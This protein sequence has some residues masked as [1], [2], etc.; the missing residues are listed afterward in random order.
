VDPLLQGPCDNLNLY[1]YVGNDPLDKTDPSG[2]DSCLTGTT[3]P[4]PPK[5]AD[6]TATQKIGNVVHNETS[7]LRPA[8]KDGAGRSKDLHDAKVAI[9][10]VV[11]NREKAGV[12]GGVASD[13]ASASEQR[14]SQYKDAQSAASEASQQKDTTGGAKNYVLDYG[15]KMP[16]WV[17]KMDASQSFGPF[18]NKSGGGD[19]TQG[20]DVTIKILVP[21]EAN[22]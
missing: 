6:P 22:E 21:K 16:G 1:T 11:E 19:V 10:H 2:N 12:N 5:P 8:S 9:A 7:G 13:K 14:T 15:Q 18:N 3:C 4:P 17:G 20:T